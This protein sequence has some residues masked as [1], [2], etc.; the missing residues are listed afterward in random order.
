M[1]FE[2]IIMKNEYKN[3]DN[4][5]YDLMNERTKRKTLHHIE[6]KTFDAN[7]NLVS[8]TKYNNVISLNPIERTHK[9]VFDTEGN[10]KRYYKYE[11]DVSGKSLAHCSKTVYDANDNVISHAQYDNETSNSPAM[12]TYRKTYYDKN[13]IIAHHEYKNDPSSWYQAHKEK[14]VYDPNNNVIDFVRY[15]NKNNPWNTNIPK[16]KLIL[17]TNYN[18]LQRV[19]YV[20]EE[21]SKNSILPMRKAFLNKCFFK[22]LNE[23]SIETKRSFLNSHLQLNKKEEILKFIAFKT[24]DLP[25]NLL[26][27]ILQSNLDLSLIEKNLLKLNLEYSL[28]FKE[29]FMHN[30][31]SF[32]ELLNVFK[33]IDAYEET[34]KKKLGQQNY[35]SFKRL[36]FNAIMAFTKL[37]QDFYKDKYL[38]PKQ[39]LREAEKTKENSKKISKR[40]DTAKKQYQKAN[41][42]ILPDNLAC[43]IL[44]TEIKTLKS[45]LD[46][47]TN[48]QELLNIC[49]SRQLTITKTTPTP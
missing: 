45:K 16:Q 14:T 8:K 4:S 21:T 42:K 26:E 23:Y 9:I 11:N 17:D 3:L 19:E 7:N 24:K 36:S 15:E 2:V 38:T 41:T 33:A 31:T 18:L 10:V 20:N 46:K 5:N 25:K 32:K 39:L 1:W 27:K 48:K 47:T 40:L 34:Y 29:K 12:A 37:S 30:E 43:K 22:T 6:K 49:N 35:T 44:K 13:K 28:D